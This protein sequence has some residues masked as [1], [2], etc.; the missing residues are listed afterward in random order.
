MHCAVTSQASCLQ[1]TRGNGHI[2]M[3]VDTK[4]VARALTSS[5][6]M[7]TRE[8]CFTIMRLS[9]SRLSLIPLTSN[10]SQV[11]PMSSTDRCQIIAPECSHH[12]MHYRPSAARS[13]YAED[14]SSFRH[15]RDQDRS[16]LMLSGSPCY[17]RGPEE[18]PGM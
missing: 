7:A 5:I 10:E 14:T 9:F 16:A 11:S 18:I 6:F 8:L 17:G 13:H 3:P 4:R 15:P 2:G 1:R 12:P